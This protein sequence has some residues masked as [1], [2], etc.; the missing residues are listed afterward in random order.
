M[1][2]YSQVKQHGAFQKAHSPMAELENKTPGLPGGGWTQGIHGHI[3]Q[4]TSKGA[5]NHGQAI[6]QTLMSALMS[7]SGAVGRNSPWLWM[8]KEGFQLQNIYQGNRET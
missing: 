6:R 3:D 4:K 1:D 5:R 8:K 2:L 7:A